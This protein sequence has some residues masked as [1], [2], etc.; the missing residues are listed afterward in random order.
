MTL[1]LIRKLLRD[2]RVGLFVTAL[3]L[4]AFQCLWARITSRIL[5]DLSPYFTQLAALA[6]QNLGDVQNQ[7]FGG[8]GKIIRTIIGGERVDLDRAMDLLSIGYVHPL[9][10]AIFCVWAVGRASGALAGEVDRGTMELLL[11]QP[12]SRPRL[13]MAHCGVDLVVIPLLCLSLW[14]GT[15]LGTWMVGPIRPAKADLQLPPAVALIVKPE[16]EAQQRERLHVDP[17]A[18]G[19][20]LPAVG[21]LLFAI[22]GY[23]MALSAAGRYRWRVLGVAVFATLIQFLVNV[24]GQLWDVMEP[25]RPFTIFYYYQPQAMILGASREEVLKSLAVLYG[26]G[27]AGYAVALWLFTRRDLPAPL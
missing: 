23:T 22:S 19:R 4:A 1:T 21:G 18:F 7:V 14:G 5:S 3:L 13:V 17:A 11:A 2:C 27:V 26:V 8:P 12:L 20:A 9:V 25:L 16:P 6:G 24:V 15:W 10:Q